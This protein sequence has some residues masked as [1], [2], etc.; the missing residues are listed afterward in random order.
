MNC[1]II[2][3][4]S[5]GR[6]HARILREMGHDVIAVSQHANSDEYE[7]QIVRDLALALKTNIIDYVVIASATH[8]HYTDLIKLSELKFQGKVLIE[9]P[10]FDKHKSNLSYYF[11]E[12]YTAYNLRFHPLL[13]DLYQQLNGEKILAAHLYAGQYLP[14]W[15]PGTDYRQSYSAKK[16]EGGGVLRDLSHELDLICWLFG[17]WGKVA[18][19][20]GK[21]SEL[22]IDSDDLWACLI[23]MKSGAAVTLQLNYLDQPG[24]R[25]LTV[26]TQNATFKLDLIKGILTKN[27]MD[28][29]IKVER[30]YTYF[31]QHEAILG[32]QRHEACKI[33]EACQV[34]KLI[35]NIEQAAE[36]TVY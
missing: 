4:G 22:L 28:K 18:A 30:D 7:Y 8:K 11:S 23:Q 25:Y 6:R 1:L 15:R 35:E 26:L 21:Q 12:V 24:G 14:D 9:K 34:L 19:I 3:H 20:G 10:L 5:I 32:N 31:A 33:D 13:Q 29:V 2:G 36:A 27:G 17:D 16:A